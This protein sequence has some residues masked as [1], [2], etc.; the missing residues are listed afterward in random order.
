MATSDLYPALRLT[1]NYTGSGTSLSNAADQAFGNLIGAI[2]APIFQGGQIRARILGQR[3]AADAAFASYRQTVLTAI[4]EVDNAYV[5]LSTAEQRETALTAADEAAR[6]A[7]LFARAQYRAG[8]IDFQTLLDSE[9]SLLS[10]QDGRASAR[11]DRARAY[12]ALYRALGGGWQ[13]APPPPAA[14]PYSP[15]RNR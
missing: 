10:S 12:V 15:Q 4:E 5:A 6:N 2:T 7:T 11:G 9:R 14:G 1:G 13:D 8:L 3:A